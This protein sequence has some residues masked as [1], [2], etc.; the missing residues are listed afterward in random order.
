MK[1]FAFLAA[2]LAT[3]FSCIADSTNLP[4]N[5]S[6]YF[7]TNTEILWQA[8]MDRLPKSFWIYRRLPQRPFLPSVISNGVILASLQDRGFPKPS[9]NAYFIWSAPNP[10]GISFSIFSIQPASTTISFSSPSQT[11]ATN[12]IPDDETVKKRAFECA[13]R[14]GLDQTQLIPKKVYS[15]SNAAGCDDTLTNGICARGIYL[16]RKL[17][18]VS[19]FGDANNG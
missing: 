4:G 1:T 3:T 12:N 6:P 18:D 5:F 19:F 10:C 9:T 8:P 13:A 16:S 11:L 17:D 14:F 15:S 2:I 7:A